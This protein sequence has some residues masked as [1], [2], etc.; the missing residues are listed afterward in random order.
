VYRGLPCVWG[1]S[2]HHAEIA[3]IDTPVEVVVKGCK[4]VSRATC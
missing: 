4:R 2:V 1:V 3:A